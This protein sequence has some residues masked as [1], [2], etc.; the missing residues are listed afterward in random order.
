LHV[1]PR[2]SLVGPLPNRSGGAQ[3]PQP[4]RQA[5][6][7]EVGVVDDRLG[8]GQPQL[9]GLTNALSAISCQLGKQ[10]FVIRPRVAKILLS[11]DSREAIDVEI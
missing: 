2:A 3:S 4:R 8:V 7:P 9:F 1:I 5:R 6:R 11:T 10:L